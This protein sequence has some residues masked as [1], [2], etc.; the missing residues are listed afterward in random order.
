MSTITSI[1]DHI[2]QP[3]TLEQKDDPNSLSSSDFMDLMLVQ[4]Q[5]QN[6]MEPMDNADYMAQMA[7]FSALEEMQAMN[8]SIGT[9]YAFGLMGKEVMIDCGNGTTVEGVV[10]SVSMTGGKNYVE[11]DG[12]MYESNLVIYGTNPE[13]VSTS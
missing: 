1:N 5:N 7:Q 3:N 11:V 12:T 6:P 13:E 4:M 8:T 2:I 9:M 10:E